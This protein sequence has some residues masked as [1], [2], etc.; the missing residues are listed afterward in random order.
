M[1]L[2][3]I[4]RYDVDAKEFK[5]TLELIQLL[6][7]I[8]VVRFVF[9]CFEAHLHQVAHDREH[10]AQIHPEAKDN[11]AKTEADNAAA[12][13]PANERRNPMVAEGLAIYER[14]ASSG[15]MLLRFAAFTSLFFNCVALVPYAAK[16]GRGLA[17][18]QRLN[19]LE[20]LDDVAL[21]NITR[22]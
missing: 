21:Q 14:C 13:K 16:F 1:G 20:L 10:A 19:E 11:E 7:L 8:C 4:W 17:Y 12:H 18:V 3:K 5:P 6:L 2:L 22:C 9:I 15:H